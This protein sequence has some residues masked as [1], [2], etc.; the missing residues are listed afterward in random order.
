MNEKK[1][2]WQYLIYL[3]SFFKISTFC[4]R[5]ISVQNITNIYNCSFAL[6]C[7]LR[8]AQQDDAVYVILIVDIIETCVKIVEI[9]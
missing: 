4:M 1:V 3:Y 5:H 9:V 6:Q 2:S 7:V 8:F